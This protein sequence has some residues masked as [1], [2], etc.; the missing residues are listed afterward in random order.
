M[1]KVP[2]HRLRLTHCTTTVPN[3]CPE[4]FTKV[5]Q[6][7]HTKFPKWNGLT[8]CRRFQGCYH[9]VNYLVANYVV[10]AGK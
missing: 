1:Q 8:V 10:F 9:R 2:T 7:S 6:R 4:F 3:H 5:H